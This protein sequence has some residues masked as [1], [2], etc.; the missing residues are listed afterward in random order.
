[1]TTG[2]APVPTTPSP[3]APSLYCCICRVTS[4]S[5]SQHEAHLKGKKHAACVAAGGI[6]NVVPPNPTPNEKALH[7]VVDAGALIK[8][9]GTELYHKAEVE[10]SLTFFG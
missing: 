3:D 5:L 8:M 10:S 1:M 6:D 2:D 9:K 4:N 7:L